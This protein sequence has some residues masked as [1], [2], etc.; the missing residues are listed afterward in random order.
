[1]YQEKLQELDL[2]EFLNLF[3]KVLEHADLVK[4]ARSAPEFEVAKS[5]KEN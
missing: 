5:F 2:K 4:F 1:M 3:E